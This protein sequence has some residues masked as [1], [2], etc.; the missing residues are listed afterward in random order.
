MVK[1]MKEISRLPL[2]VKLLVAVTVYGFKKLLKSMDMFLLKFSVCVDGCSIDGVVR[3][4]CNSIACFSL[5]WWCIIDI[6]AFYFL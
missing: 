5:F 3:A 4:T 1:C 2:Y 6:F